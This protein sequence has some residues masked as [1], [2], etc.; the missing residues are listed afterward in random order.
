MQTNNI[1]LEREVTKGCHQGSGCGPGLW[2]LQYNSLL[3][4]NYTNRTKAIA[5]ADDMIIVTS[6]KTV[7]EAE[8]IPNIELSKISFSAKDKIRFNEQKSKAMLLTRRK[9]RERKELEIYLNYKPL[10]QVYRL[11]YLGIILDNKLTFRD[12]IIAMTIKCSKLIF[13]LSK[14]AKL[15]WGLNYAALK[16]IYTEGTLPLLLYEAPVWINAN[17]QASYKLKITRVQRLINIRL[18][19][20]YRTVSNEALCLIT[21]LIPIDIKI[22]ETAQLYQLTRGSTK[23]EAKIDQDMGIKH[24]LHPAVKITILRDNNEDSST[25]QIFTDGSKSEQGVGAGIAVY[26]SGTQPKA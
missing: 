9:L 17:N 22:E 2:N 19:R 1:R 10:M 11:K 16:T 26:R 13:T 12:H 14:S 15:K 4:L 8:N 21:G 23:E 7:R 24:W 18:A 25:T 5:Y 6:G 20:A 3:N